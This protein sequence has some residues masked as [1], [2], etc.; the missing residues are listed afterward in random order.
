MSKYTKSVKQQLDQYKMLLIKAFKLRIWTHNSK[1]KTKTNKSHSSKSSLVDQMYIFTAINLYH[2]DLLFKKKNAWHLQSGHQ[3]QHQR[4][5]TRR[6]GHQ[7][8]KH[9]SFQ[10][11][12]CC[13]S[14]QNWNNTQ[15]L[16]TQDAQ[17]A[18]ERGCTCIKIK[19]QEEE[20]EGDKEKEGG[21]ER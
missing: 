15:S 12:I 18:N 21:R 19:E 2:H 8:G 6:L 13:S 16:N 14:D 9:T 20:K 5:V 3:K 17:G 7:P 1:Q 11:K 4:W 10:T